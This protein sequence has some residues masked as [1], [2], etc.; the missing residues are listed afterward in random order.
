MASGVDTGASWWRHSMKVSETN[1]AEPTRILV[2][3]DEH[4][5]RDSLCRALASVSPQEPLEV[6][7]ARTRDELLDLIGPGGHPGPLR[8]DLVV[9]DLF[10]GTSKRDG[11]EV[12]QQI[13]E[14]D[15]ELPIIIISDEELSLEEAALAFREGATDVMRRARGHELTDRLIL[16]VH[17]VRSIIKLA[18]ANRDLR[19]QATKATERAQAAEEDLD[20]PFAEMVGEDPAFRKVLDIIRRVAPIPRP[21]LILGERGT[22]KELIAR[23]LHKA[24]SRSD[25]PFVAVNCAA[26]EENVLA[27]ELFGHER[28]AF[29]GADR[30]RLGRFERADG[31]TLFLDEIGHMSLEFQKKILRVIE[32]PKFERVGGEKPITVDARVIAA[33]NIDLRV[34]MRAGRFLRDLFDRLAFEIIEIPPLRDRRTDIEPLAEHFMR[35]FLREVPSLGRKVLA[36]DALTALRAYP[37]PGN[38]RELKNI[39]ERAVYRD[40]TN[41]IDRKDLLL[42][43]FNPEVGVDPDSDLPFKEQIKSL[44]A[45]LIREALAECNGNNRKAAAKLGLTYDQ[46]KHIKK[47]LNLFKKD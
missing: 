1:M 24:G 31:G 23:A 5:V 37:F 45:R 11:I 44:E 12:M 10:L 40:T 28:G 6:R 35:Q 3:D 9:V 42:Y 14:I 19:A 41:V 47:R 22:G 46:L 39:I 7:A 32:Y 38:V 21:V 15:Q 29:T 34:E 2:L 26:F 16:E 36:P 18:R 33:T 27:S 8:W 25:G 30:K 17:K 20:A 13:R 4:V 43:P